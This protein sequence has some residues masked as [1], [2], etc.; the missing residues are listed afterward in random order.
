[1]R[2]IRGA[3]G[4]VILLLVA[5]G[6]TADVKLPFATTE[7]KYQE[8]VREQVVD[9]VLEAVEQATVS[10]QTSGRIVEINY[11]VDDFVPKDSVL[12]RFRDKEQRAALKAAEAKHEAAQSSFQRIMDLYKK[13]LVSKSEFDKAEAALKGARAT[14]EQAQ[15]QLAHTVVKAPYSGIMVERHVEVGELARPG[16]PLM[17][18]LSLERLRAIASVSQAHIDQVRSISQARVILPTQQNKSI[19]AAKLTFTP[20][21]DPA[22]HT[23]KVRV[24]LPAGRHG[25]YPGMFVKTAFVVGKERRLVVDERA[26]AYRSEV[27]AVYVLDR[28]GDVSFRH[29]RTGRRLDNGNVEVLAGLE[30][31]ERV[32]LDP[33]RAGVYLKDKRADKGK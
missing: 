13:N 15:E 25:V 10:A 26:V 23:F 28:E 32:A 4:F 16:T 27:T 30:A 5:R 33:V 12:L 18:G 31:G 19:D 14:L 8:V 3:L 29:I 22:S 21:A 7:V 2:I 6:G 20:F 9:A 24:D 11:D 17:T 1:M